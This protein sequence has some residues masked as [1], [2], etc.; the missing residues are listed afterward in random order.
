MTETELLRAAYD[1]TLRHLDGLQ[2]E[3][4]QRRT[5]CAD[6][7]VRALLAHVVAAN[8]GLVAM[9]H[10]EQPDW[11]KDALG[12][13][14]A[15]AVRR[16][17]TG[18][19]AAWSEPGAVDVPSR[20]MPGMR[21]VDFAVADAV[22]HAWD[23]AAALGRRLELDDGQVAGVLERWDGAPADTGRQY[24]AFGPRVEVPADAPA[25]DRLLGAF[26]RDPGFRP[27]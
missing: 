9:L 20:Q 3:D 5:P 10:G 11:K 16:A 13:D 26:G 21:I 7:D 17:L 19:L 27:V 24:G 6:W 15:G 1:Q 4:L 23:L 12:D 14:P 18:S 25:L 22:V 8:D 2:A